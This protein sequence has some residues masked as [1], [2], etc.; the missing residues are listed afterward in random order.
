MNATLDR[1]GR[2][3]IDG[4]QVGWVRPVHDGSGAR[5]IGWEYVVVNTDPPVGS[6][7]DQLD[8]SLGSRSNQTYRTKR[9]AKDALLERLS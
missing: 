4:W 6:R 7:S 2:V 1:E 3:Y 9:E 5:R 8:P